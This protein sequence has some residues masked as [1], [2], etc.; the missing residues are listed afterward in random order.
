[1]LETKNLGK[2]YLVDKKPYPA[3]SNVSLSFPEVQFVAVLG[4]SG[5]GKT[6]LLNL[7]GGLDRP[8]EGDIYF[9]GEPLSKKNEKELDS[10]RNNA[11][12]FVFQNYY[13]IPQLSV[14]ENVKVALE[15][16]DTDEKSGTE[17]AQKTLKEVGIEES[18]WNKK[19]NQLSGGQAQRVAIARALVTD[20]KILLADEPTGALDSENSRLIMDILKQCSKSHLVILV[21]HNEELAQAYADRIIRLKDGK[22]E[23]DTLVNEN[24][25]EEGAK[26]PA[27][28]SHLSFFLQIKLALRNMRARFGKSILTAV[29]NSFALIGIGFLLS[30]NLGFREYST[31]LSEEAAASLPVVINAYNA[32]DTSEAFS[33]TNASVAYPDTEE[34][35]PSVDTDS[36]RTY[37]ANQ[38]SGKYFS[39]LQSLEKEG[40]LKDYTINYGADYSFNLTTQFPESLDGKYQASYREVY[41]R[42]TSWNYYAYVSSLPY[43]IFHVLYGNLDDYDLIAGSYPSDSS[44]L[45]LVVNRYNAISFSILQQLGFYSPYDNQE[46]VKDKNLSTKVKPISFKEVLSKEY[47]IFLNCTYFTKA[48]EKE[49]TDAF[50]NKRT[51]SRYLN[52]ELTS[53]F[54]ESGKSLHITGI[55][56]PKEASA[57][58]LLSPA[59][60]YL[61]SLQEELMPENEKSDFANCFASDV[62]FHAKSG[63]E[64]GTSAAVSFAN[65]LENELSSYLSGDSEVLPTDAI[66]TVL[67]NYFT[68]YYPKT[69]TSDIS[70]YYVYTSFD[71]FLSDARRYGSSL[72]NDEILGKNL[73]DREL[74]QEEVD[75]I[76]ADLNA[77]TGSDDTENIQKL[78]DDVLSLV[79]YS[80]AYSLISSVVLFPQNLEA[81]SKLLT[82]LDDYNTIVKDSD[83]HAS[84][85]SEQVFYRS[86]ESNAMVEDVGEMIGLVSSILII[87][88]IVSSIVAIALTAVLTSNNVIERRKEIGLL[89]SLGSRKQDV[90]SLFEWEALFQAILAGIFGSLFTFALSF[91]VNALLQYYYPSYHVGSICH[92]TWYHGLILLAFALVL[93]L[94]AS[95]VPAY[96]ASRQD[97]VKALRTE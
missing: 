50:G 64:E 92:F 11:I 22:V 49:V 72:V 90:I 35:Y 95:L 12:G 39:Y 65:D 31:R 4:P 42:L 15:V 81:R 85:A 74:L 27:R 19:P 43:N 88:A 55:L 75:K 86:E 67:N 47:R 16:R 29:A 83:S 58:T 26:I 38:F 3:L 82:K 53:E 24:F 76:L 97:P 1:M 77:I 5:C 2:K 69:S 66:D 54:Y 40:I 21:T 34:I 84:S 87:F 91:P 51:I 17:K 62:V 70:N 36:S 78:Y 56:R 48:D 59:L 13:L 41:T 14:L 32:K 10:Y 33:D 52:P 6:T 68:C 28:K 60:C 71:S 20:P 73:A 89:R 46:E 94:L 63:Q 30:M 7:L 79:A 8:S 18:L 93:G 45:V 23:D 25:F 96:K 37:T 57:Y 80:K 44:G 9:Q 61:P